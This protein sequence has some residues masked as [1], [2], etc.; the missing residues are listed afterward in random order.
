VPRDAPRIV[1]WYRADATTRIRRVLFAGPAALTLGG[2]VIAVSFLA[3]QPR[4]I[5]IDAAALG[6]VL[7]AGGA[8]Y[9]MLGMQRIL[10][11]DLCVALRTD[12]LMIQSVAGDTLITWDELR[13]ASWDAAREELVLQRMQD[14]PVV[15]ARPFARITGAAMAVQITSIQRKAAM[16]L[17]R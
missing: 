1:E 10:R 9:T 6:F 3:H 7:I 15:L 14:G 8:L 4:A 16:N 13:E 2:L 11:D 17:L 5:R 12:G